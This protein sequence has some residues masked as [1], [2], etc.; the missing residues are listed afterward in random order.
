MQVRKGEQQLKQ[1]D[2][3]NW[4]VTLTSL[5]ASQ[6]S[7]TSSN[8]LSIVDQVLSNG[9]IDKSSLV[10]LGSTDMEL[11]T[12]FLNRVRITTLPGGMVSDLK[13]FLRFK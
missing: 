1:K 10:F 2:K 13:C 8:V 5:E 4:N 11:K 9:L 7:L 12:D 6:S 3:S